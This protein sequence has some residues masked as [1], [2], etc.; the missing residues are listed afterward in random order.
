MGE[1][2]VLQFPSAHL[3]SERSQEQVVTHTESCSLK[4]NRSGK[5]LCAVKSHESLGRRVW[6]L[7]SGRGSFAEFVFRVPV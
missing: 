7:G 4:T 1:T 3:L 5:K 2:L 6:E